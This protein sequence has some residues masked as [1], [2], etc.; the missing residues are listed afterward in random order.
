[1]VWRNRSGPWR[2]DLL[3][4]WRN[5]SGPWRS[6]LLVGWRTLSGPWRSDLLVGW[7]TRSGPWRSDLLEEL[8]WDG[9][10]VKALQRVNVAPTQQHVIH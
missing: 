3:V 8:A 7:R 1:M 9:L 6:D 4:G 5:L 2:S 10:W